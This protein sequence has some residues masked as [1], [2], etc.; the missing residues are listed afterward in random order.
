[1]GLGKTLETIA[2]L[3]YLTQLQE[4]SNLRENQKMKHL[5]IIPK[6][7]L[8]NWKSEFKLWCPYLR[9][10]ILY[11]EDKEIRTEI[12]N[13]LNQHKAFDIAVTSYEAVSIEQASLK[14]INWT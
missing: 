14:R 12:A 13:S 9:V 3:A 1:M 2:L 4:E 10:L 8:S 6:T 5:I 7:T 11:N